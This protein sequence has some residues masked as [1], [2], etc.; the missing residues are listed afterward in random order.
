M[1][2]AKDDFLRALGSANPQESEA[3]R[4]LKR[5]SGELLRPY[6]ANPELERGSSGVQAVEYAVD[7]DSGWGKLIVGTNVRIG[8]TSSKTGQGE[9]CLEAIWAMTDMYE[10]LL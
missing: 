8:E 7:D 1:N 2:K 9:C 5:T 10:F 4:A 6:S 3:T